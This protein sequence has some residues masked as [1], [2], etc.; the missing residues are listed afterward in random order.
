[1]VH[2][3]LFLSS[4][5]EGG[6]RVFRVSSRSRHGVGYVIVYMQ[7]ATVVTCDSYFRAFLFSVGFFF[8]RLFSRG[9]VVP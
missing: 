4:V 9:V 7:H 8:C 1:M 5:E 6:Q 2:G 3:L